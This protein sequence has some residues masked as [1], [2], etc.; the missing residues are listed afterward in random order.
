MLARTDRLLLHASSLSFAHPST[1]EP[2][3]V[4]SAAPF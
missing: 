4:E 2:I 1:G 3:T